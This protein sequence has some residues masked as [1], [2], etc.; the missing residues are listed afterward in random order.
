[1]QLVQIQQQDK[2]MKKKRCLVC[3]KEY[4][5][6]YK[7][8]QKQWLGRK[9][10]SYPC[11]YEAN[12]TKFKKGNPA[13]KTA[14]KKGVSASPKT[15]FKKGQVS[16]NKGK[17]LEY[18]RGAKSRFWKGGITPINQKIRHSVE[19]KLW[20]TAVF[21]RDNWTCIWCG[22]RGGKLNADHIK[23]FAYY[24]ELRFA[25]DNGRTLCVKCHRTTDN[26]AGKGY[27]R[28]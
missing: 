17:V 6:N 25:I 28:K 12:P 3:N 10:C 18:L 15:Q 22:Q 20:R 2:T 1:M 24:P 4:S 14:F 9:Y 27:K 5:K 16:W 19:Y 8:S 13:P 11:M 26:Y 7:E 23:A 21:E